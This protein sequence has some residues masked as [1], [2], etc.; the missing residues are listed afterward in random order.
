MVKILRPFE[1]AT[2]VVSNEGSSATLV[3][4]ELNSLVHFLESTTSDDEESIQTIKRKMLLSLNSRYATKELNKLY[5]LPTLLDSC[6]KI[7]VFSSSTAVIQARQWL[8]EEFYF[9]LVSNNC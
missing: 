1:E 4:P 6:F 5:A 9:M 3:I 2:V 7:R 8:A